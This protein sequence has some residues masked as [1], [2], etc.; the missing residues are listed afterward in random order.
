MRVRL[1]EENRNSTYQKE[2]LILGG[3]TELKPYK[4][5]KTYAAKNVAF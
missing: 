5:G 1:T 3:E 2:T 4:D